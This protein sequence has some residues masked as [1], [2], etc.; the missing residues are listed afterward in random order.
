MFWGLIVIN[1]KCGSTTH[2]GQAGNI[3]NI[4][5]KGGI[6]PDFYSYLKIISGGFWGPRYGREKYGHLK[7]SQIGD[8]VSKKPSSYNLE[9]EFLTHPE[10]AKE[11]DKNKKLLRDLKW[12]MSVF[13]NG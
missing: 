5:I 13:V 12:D 4:H 7:I 1:Y 2:R 8:L 3:I 9:I 11:S 10:T 6:P